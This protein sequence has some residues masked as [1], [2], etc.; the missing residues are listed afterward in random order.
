LRVAGGKHLKSA[1]EAYRTNV[2]HNNPS[3]HKMN[4]DP[5]NRL[6]MTDRVSIRAVLVRDGDDV[7][8]ALALAGIVDP[9]AI[10]VLTGEDGDAFPG[11]LGDG[12][13]PNLT[14]VLEPDDADDVGPAPVITAASDPADR[15]AAPPR[16]EMLP[17]RHGMQPLAPVRR[18][19]P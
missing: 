3:R 4:D 13:T 17:A 8:R 9:V 19:A 2:E 5:T 16:T 7:N 14:G 1:L 18:R 11:L 12:I 6:A 15:P 10:P